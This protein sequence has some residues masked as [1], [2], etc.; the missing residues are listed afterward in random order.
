MT[1]DRDQRSEERREEVP[2][3]KPYVVPAIAEEEVFSTFTLGCAK[4]PRTSCGTTN[5]MA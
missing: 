2:I 5:V 3:K 4:R 1:E